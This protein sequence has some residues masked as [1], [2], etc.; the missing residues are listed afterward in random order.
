MREVPVTERRHRVAD[1][2]NVPN[3]KDK[4]SKGLEDLIIAMLGDLLAFIIRVVVPTFLIMMALVCGL[5]FSVYLVDKM[6][7]HDQRKADV[8]LYE[9]AVVLGHGAWDKET[10]KFY[11]KT[12]SITLENE[13]NTRY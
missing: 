11:W 1:N 4:M 3:P 13:R 5:G 12:N 6:Q 7:T 10:G 9:Q 2:A 8:L